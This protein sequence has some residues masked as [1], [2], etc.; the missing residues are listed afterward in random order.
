MT[1]N[2]MKYHRVLSSICRPAHAC[3]RPSRHSTSPATLMIRFMLFLSSRFSF[4]F[5]GPRVS[6]H[7]PEQATPYPSKWLLRFFLRRKAM[8]HA[9][10]K[11]PTSWLLPMWLK[12]PWLP[13]VLYHGKNRIRSY[14][15]PLE[16]YFQVKKRA[17]HHHFH[18]DMLPCVPLK[19]QPP[20]SLRP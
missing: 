19:S 9:V 4:L 13:P 14:Y 7:Q 16:E 1:K 15:I 12:V 3:T 17:A 2:A 5:A 8:T 10:L 11:F 20:R 18:S 6:L